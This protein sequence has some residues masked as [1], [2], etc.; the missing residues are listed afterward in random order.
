MA[1]VASLAPDWV[2]EAYAVSGFVF[3]SLY[4]AVIFWVM[5]LGVG[6]LFAVAKR[7]LISAAVGLAG[8]CAILFSLPAI[9]HLLSK[10]SAS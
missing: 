3:Y 6:T 9:Q 7:S 2:A 4:L 10:L 5:K 8:G 1:L